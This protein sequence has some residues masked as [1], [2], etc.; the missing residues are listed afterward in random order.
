MNKSITNK[1]AYEFSHESPFLQDRVERAK[2]E[3]DDIILS[4]LLLQER[5]AASDL[6]MTASSNIPVDTSS[7]ALSTFSR[8]KA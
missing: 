1:K 2:S 5:T 4:Y 7:R 8:G 3:D 6:E